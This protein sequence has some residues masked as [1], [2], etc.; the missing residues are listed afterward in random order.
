MVASNSVGSDWSGSPA[1]DINEPQLEEI[2]SSL[3]QAVS[4]LAM[5]SSEA[6]MLGALRASSEEEIKRRTFY[7]FKLKLK[8]GTALDSADV[9]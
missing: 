1:R 8:L 7:K 4:L 2:P 5:S 3:T 6:L 9:R